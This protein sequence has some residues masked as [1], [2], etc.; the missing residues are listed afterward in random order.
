MQTH[1]PRFATWRGDG[2]LGIN[3]TAILHPRKN[4]PTGESR[5]VFWRAQNPV[6]SPVEV[7]RKNPIMYQ[8]FFSTISRWLFGG[9]LNHQLYGSNFQKMGTIRWP[10]TRVYPTKTATLMVYQVRKKTSF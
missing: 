2:L 10:S 3:V 4:F 1:F 6:D 9:F 7:D 8:V 5:R